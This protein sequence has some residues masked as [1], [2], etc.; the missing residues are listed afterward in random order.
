MVPWFQRNPLS[1]Q[2]QARPFSVSGNLGAPNDY[3]YQFVNFLKS[4]S[5]GAEVQR[6]PVF[7]CSPGFEQTTS[8]LYSGTLTCQSSGHEF[9]PMGEFCL[10][11]EKQT[12]SEP[13][14]GLSILNDKTGRNSWGF[15][16]PQ[17]DRNTK[18]FRS[19]SEFNTSSLITS[20]D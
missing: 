16:K 1:P 8:E 19:Q 13:D 18:G 15:Y 5:D 9:P 12:R 3:L 17:W 2:K 14:P 10:S 4:H 11:E 6:L 7:S 20:I